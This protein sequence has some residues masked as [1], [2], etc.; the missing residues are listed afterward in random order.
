MESLKVME[1]FLVIALNIPVKFAQVFQST[2]LTKVNG[3]FLY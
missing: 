2:C 3:P 1:L